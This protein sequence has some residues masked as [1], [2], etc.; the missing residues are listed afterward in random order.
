ME[1][2]KCEILLAE[3]K[4]SI[5]KFTTLTKFYSEEIEDKQASKQLKII[6]TNMYTIC[7]EKLT[8]TEKYIEYRDEIL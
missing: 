8:V 3:E 2:D 6:K 5:R 1:E 7:I 4:I